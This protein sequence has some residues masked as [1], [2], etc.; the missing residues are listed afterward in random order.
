[1]AYNEGDL[2]GINDSYQLGNYVFTAQ[3][4]VGEGE[5]V[6]QVHVE[7]DGTVWVR[8]ISLP[9]DAQI[10]GWYVDSNEDIASV[11]VVLQGETIPVV[12]CGPSGGILGSGPDDFTRIYM[13]AEGSGNLT[14]QVSGNSY[15]VLA[16]SEA[17]GAEIR[18]SP[19]GVSFSL[20]SSYTA[21]DKTVY[22]GT[23]SRTH[24]YPIAMADPL[25]ESIVPVNKTAWGMIY[26]AGSGEDEDKL[27][28]QFRITLKEAGGGP[29]G[30]EDPDTGD[31]GTWTEPGDIGYDDEPDET[32]TL[33][34]TVRGAL[35][36]RHNDPVVNPSYHYLPS[37]KE[38]EADYGCGGDGGNGGGG[39]SGASTVAIRKFA[40]GR[41][42][43]K[44][45]VAL[46]R[47]HGYGSGGGEGAQGGYG[48]HIVYY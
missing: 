22:Y 35:S 37:P 31:S 15:V 12:P 20:T 28:A 8:G 26:G 41:A 14:F 44:E 1:M 6:F 17:A 43:A 48:M 3:T 29:A 2:V 39:G 40:T 25:A 34:L 13:F 46:A 30:W 27:V 9:E 36:G 38:T 5:R 42:D 47:R 21:H 32:K 45:I 16:A 4:I 11:Y 23:F 24:E 18:T 7:H 33:Y 19:A 10:V